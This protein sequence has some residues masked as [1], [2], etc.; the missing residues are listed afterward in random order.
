MQLTPGS[1]IL[2]E[3]VT[4]AHLFKK[5]LA[6]M[7]TKILL[8]FSLEPATGRNPEPDEINRHSRSLFLQDPFILS[9]YLLQGLQNSI[10]QSNSPTKH[11]YLYFLSP[12]TCYMIRPSYVP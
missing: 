8:P 7:E 2:P 9:S 4:V 6:F 1:T 12:P 11:L 10:I 5:L 3:K